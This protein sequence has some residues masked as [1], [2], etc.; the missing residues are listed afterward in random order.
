MKNCNYLQAKD[1][2]PHF[3]PLSPNYQ[4]L[5]LGSRMILDRD[6]SNLVKKN[7][8]NTREKHFKGSAEEID[9]LPFSGPLNL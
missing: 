2:L 3:S 5:N 7:Y 4:L 6:S 9:H 1:K 8:H